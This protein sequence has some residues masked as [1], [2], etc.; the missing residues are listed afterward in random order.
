MKKINYL[1]CVL[2]SIT[3]MF[4][5]ACAGDGAGSQSSETSEPVSAT[6]TEYKLEGQS[7]AVE[8]DVSDN[9]RTF[10]EIFT[11]SFSDSNGDGVGDLRG[12]I[13]RMDYLNDGDPN[14]GLSLGIEGIWLTPIFKSP[15][16]HK[17]DVTDYY[18]I[19]PS[20]GTLDDLKDL[21]ALC[22]ERNVK[23]IIDL[24]INH[25]S[26]NCEWFLKF[27]AAHVNADTAS[28]YYNFYSYY[29]KGGTA[30]SGS[31]RFNELSGANLLYECN[32]DG[33]MPEP[34][35]DNQFVRDTFLDVAKYYLELG[36]DGFRFDAAKY[37]YY[38]E[39][40][41]SAEFWDW[42]IGELKKVKSDVYTVSEVWDGDQVTYPYFKSGNCFDFTSDGPDGVFADAAQKGDVN[43][44]TRYIAGYLKNIKAKNP[45]AMMV[46]FLSNH[47]TDRSIGYLFGEGYVNMAA[48]LYLLSTG[49]P[50]IYYGEEVGMRGSRGSDTTDANIRLAM[51][52]GDGDTVANPE[53]ATYKDSAQT[54]PVVAE[55]ILD[56]NSLYNYYKRLIA[57]RKANPE[58]ARG[59]YVAMS[60][61][62][63]KASGFKATYNGST[64][65]VLHNTS[66][67]AV[68]LDLSAYADKTDFV[69]RAA[70]GY[71]E[72]TVMF[73]GAKI[74][75][76]SQTSVVL[77]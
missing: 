59:E 23:L 22:H 49:S 62:G 44:M 29:T 2:L 25:T 31:R 43:T 19:D 35:F 33:G 45:D 15:T 38:G 65:Y 32:F 16:Y 58:I 26:T 7:Y 68:T 12:I 21:I 75:I 1:I 69:I 41:K 54:S 5:T 27:R 61:S 74:T 53:G 66:G 64:V 50:F 47:D 4:V 67:S 10:Y 71:G 70:I 57:I 48:N 56:E 76:A 9:Y 40:A 18:T 3:V 72:N 63:V 37:I 77:K 14:S 60:F 13:N 39:N 55:Q 36:L 46:P 30:P 73:D 28:E 51:R 24:P 52:W 6:P 34:D 17:Y 8:E 42:Y 11:C 20:F